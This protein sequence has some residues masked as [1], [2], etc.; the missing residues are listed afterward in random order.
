MLLILLTQL[1]P[2]CSK[3]CIFSPKILIGSKNPLVGLVIEEGRVIITFLSTIWLVLPERHFE[4]PLSFVMM[5][6]SSPLHVP[7]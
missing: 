7:L 3:M 1:R 2:S 6:F 5:Q 4:R